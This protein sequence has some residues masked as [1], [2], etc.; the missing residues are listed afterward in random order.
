MQLPEKHPHKS[1][2]LSRQRTSRFFESC[3]YQIGGVKIAPYY[4][5]DLVPSN[6]LL[7]PQ[8]E[9]MDRGNECVFCGVGSILLFSGEQKTGATLDEVY[10]PK[11]LKNKNG[12]S[13]KIISTFGLQ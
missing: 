6:Y 5:P 9:K 12:L 3:G 4:F 1:C 11:M 8:Y 13:R 2:Y 10:K 7:T